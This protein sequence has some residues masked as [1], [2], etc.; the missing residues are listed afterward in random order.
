[1]K[2]TF[3]NHEVILLVDAAGKRSEF[4]RGW[5]GP[6]GRTRTLEEYLEEC[7]G[8]PEVNACL[9]AELKLTPSETEY[10]DLMTKRAFNKLA[11]MVFH[12]P[13]SLSEEIRG[14]VIVLGELLKGEGIDIR[15]SSHPNGAPA[16]EVADPE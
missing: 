2:M 14:A 13:R 1:M 11:T 4:D 6:Y 12:H 7:G 15:F 5:G 10:A 8:D 16:L 3:T 9:L